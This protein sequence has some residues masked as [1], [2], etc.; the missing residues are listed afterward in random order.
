M[1]LFLFYG[2]NWKYMKKLNLRKIKI[3]IAKKKENGIIYCYKI[4]KK[5]YEKCKR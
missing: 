5:R 3:H 1:G 2:Y 4:N